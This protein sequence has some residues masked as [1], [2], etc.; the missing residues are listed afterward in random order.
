MR[1][2]S[3]A[4]LSSALTGTAYN[5]IVQLRDEI[6]AAI[7]SKGLRAS[8][9]TQDSL[10]IHVDGD[11]V[12]LEGRA[13]FSALQYGSAP[14]SGRT[15]IKCTYEEFKGIIRDWSTM[16]N[17]YDAQ[18]LLFRAQGLETDID[19]L[20]VVFA[21][22]LDFDVIVPRAVGRRQIYLFLA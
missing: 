12:T 14:W 22:S 13:F 4:E 18:L 8:G 3:T 15:G 21:S 20:Q 5:R 7:A 1:M 11:V 17:R 2:T 16:E 9:R 19:A 6:R 10:R